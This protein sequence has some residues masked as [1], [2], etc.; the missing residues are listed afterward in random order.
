MWKE[1]SLRYTC[2]QNPDQGKWLGWP[3][4]SLQGERLDNQRQRSMGKKQVSRLI[5][6]KWGH[7]YTSYYLTSE[8]ILHK[9]DTQQSGRQD[10]SSCG[11]ETSSLL[12]HSSVGPLIDLFNIKLKNILRSDNNQTEPRRMACSW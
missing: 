6:V 10:D 8:S 4:I 1:N 5:Y 3:V 2:T 7:S 12:S 9:G 11:Y